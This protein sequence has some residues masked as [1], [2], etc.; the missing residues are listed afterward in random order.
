MNTQ[1]YYR[2]F[3]QCLN[4]MKTASE[5][6]ESKRIKSKLKVNGAQMIANGT[7]MQKLSV[8]EYI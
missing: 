1:D 2:C 3:N 7:S 6:P 5:A 4:R 8:D